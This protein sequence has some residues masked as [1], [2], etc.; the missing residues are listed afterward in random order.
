M[1]L[2]MV[3]AVALAIALTSTAGV[4]ATPPAEPPTTSPPPVPPSRDSSRGEEHGT[5]GVANVLPGFSNPPTHRDAAGWTNPCT[6]QPTPP[7]SEPADLDAVD[8][9][10]DLAVERVEVV[11]TYS[12]FFS[13]P[14]GLVMNDVDRVTITEDGDPLAFDVRARENGLID[15]EWAIETSI[16][17]EFVVEYVQWRTGCRRPSDGARTGVDRYW[18]RVPTNASVVAAALLEI[19]ERLEAPYVQWPDRDRE[20]GWVYVNVD[21]DL[22]IAPIAPIS[23]TRTESNVAGAVTVTVAA[24]PSAVA[25]ESGEPGA[26]GVVCSYAAVTAP[27]FRDAASACYF[28]YSHSSSGEPDSVFRATATLSWA[29][30]ATGGITVL[31]PLSSATESLAVAEV[32]SI[33]VAD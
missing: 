30:T 32:Q 16:D 2:T 18:V 4:F 11:E 31:D 33:V 27:V 15:G 21:N 14:A 17:H 23:E 22:R 9:E 5:V 28:R 29:V 3:I 10:A 13:E 26:G 7:V 1:R 24:A 12:E 19:F 20:F 6:P 25:F 8:G